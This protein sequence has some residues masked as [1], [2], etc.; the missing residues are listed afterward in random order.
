M[1]QTPV[2]T[3]L[4]LPTVA[5]T[6]ETIRTATVGAQVNSWSAKELAARPL[7]DAADLLTDAGVYVKSYGLGSL[8]TGATRGGAAGHTLVLW[9]GLPIGSPMLGMTDLSLLPTAGFDAASFTRGGDGALWGSGAIGGVL[10]LRS[11]TA[12]GNGTTVRV[13][14]EIG[15]FGLR[16]LN[17]GVG[18]SRRNFSGQTNLRHRSATNDFRYAPA[19]ASPNAPRPTR[20]CDRLYLHRTWRGDPPPAASCRPTSGTSR[21]NGSCPR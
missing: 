11:E 21:A 6:G 3:L 15:S 18:V 19:P 20:R 7:G 12:F 14:T 10:D 1:A 17:G 4:E 16:E 8:A 13:G 9:N 2:D 5:V